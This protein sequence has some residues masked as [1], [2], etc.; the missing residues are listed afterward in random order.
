MRPLIHILSLGATV[1]SLVLCVAFVALGVRSYLNW[2][3]YFRS[4]T[5]TWNVPQGMQ[6]AEF[7]AW[8]GWT[9]GDLYAARLHPPL[10]YGSDSAGMSVRGGWT[11]DAPQSRV[12]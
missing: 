7:M 11:T 1:L 5:Y 9:R 3:E 4:V 10:R 2:D 8:V 12:R 6:S